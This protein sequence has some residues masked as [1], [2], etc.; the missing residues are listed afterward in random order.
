MIETNKLVGGYIPNY[1]AIVNADVIISLNAR[2]ERKSSS[3]PGKLLKFWSQ[4]TDS[5]E[6]R[7]PWLSFPHKSCSLLSSKLE[8][9]N[10]R[11]LALTE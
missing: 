7:F 9:K 3:F 11:G 6:A 2:Q 4:K 5:K 10:L 1:E 8:E